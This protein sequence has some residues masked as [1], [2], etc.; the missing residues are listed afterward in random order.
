MLETAVRK[1]MQVHIQGEVLRVEKVNLLCLNLPQ[2]TV[3]TLFD[4]LTYI[5][6]LPNHLDKFN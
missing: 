5:F 4:S 2:G 1:Q 3:T 6:S